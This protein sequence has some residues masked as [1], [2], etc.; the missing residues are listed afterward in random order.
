MLRGVT[1][2][3]AFATERT[4]PI[5][6]LKIGNAASANQIMSVMAVG[7][8]TRALSVVAGLHPKTPCAA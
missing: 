5:V 1:R 4:R 2:E 3:L 8:D 6:W 7:T